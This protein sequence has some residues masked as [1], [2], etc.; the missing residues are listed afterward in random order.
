[1]STLGAGLRPGNFV[2]RLLAEPRFSWRMIDGGRRSGYQLD[3]RGQV[4]GPP[5]E[6]LFPQ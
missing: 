1:M 5:A 2:N 6:H 4:P 3:D